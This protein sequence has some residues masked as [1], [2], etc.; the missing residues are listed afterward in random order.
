MDSRSDHDEHATERCLPSSFVL[1]LTAS[2]ALSIVSAQSTGTACNAIGGLASVSFTQDGGAS[3]VP[4]HRPLAAGTATFGLTALDVPGGMVAEYVGT[5]YRSTSDGCR[6]SRL[7]TA[8]T[9]LL[10]LTAGVGDEAWAW[11]FLGGHDVWRS[12]TVPGGAGI[13]RRKGLPADVLT[14]A[15]DPLDGAHL[16]AVGEDG[17]IYESFDAATS[18]I[19][20]GRRAPVPLLVYFAAINPGNPDNVMI[21]VVTDGIW[22]TVD[23]GQTWNQAAG[24]SA[25]GG[26]VNGFTGRFAAADADVAWA[27]AIDLDQTGDPSGGRHI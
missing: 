1:A 4:N 8:E 6:W 21:G 24:L 27:M 3:Y 9:S 7:G 19:P 22:T 26:S 15:V 5:V 14:L 2:G 25:T 20:R 17:Q 16:H 12:D 13:E 11:S 23:G 18:W 10:R